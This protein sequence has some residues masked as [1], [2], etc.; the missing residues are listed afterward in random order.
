MMGIKVD[1]NEIMNTINHSL[2]KY[3]KHEI[4]GKLLTSGGI[5][6][7]ELEDKEYVEMMINSEM[8]QT[9]FTVLQDLKKKYKKEL[10]IYEDGEEVFE[11]YNE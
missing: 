1:Y 2:V 7:H 9:S 10:E 3:K 5:T 6:I 8:E 4:L 11:E